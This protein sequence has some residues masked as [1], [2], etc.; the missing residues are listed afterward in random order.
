M[1]RFIDLDTWKR[2]EHFKIYNALAQPFW[3]IC[4]EV[5]VTRLWERSRG[6][7]GPSFSLGAIYLALVAVQE[8]ESF[9]L[10]LRADQVWLHDEVAM[11]TTV[12]RADDTFAFALLPMANSL[13]DFESA[14]R[15]E[16]DIAKNRP[17][18]RTPRE[19]Q[20]DLIYHSTIPWIRFT[21]FSNPV[22]Q[23]DCIPRIVFGRA[24]TEGS[25]V[26]LPVSIEVHHALVDG[27]DVARFLERFERGLTSID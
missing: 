4:T 16:L 10:R 27:L 1:G 17:E 6:T 11:S 21:A 2:R 13:A 23:G 26:R 8:T 12:L 5:D 22:G 15:V 3:G 9:R 24:S 25:R 7:T 14:A 19:G 18:L 20:D